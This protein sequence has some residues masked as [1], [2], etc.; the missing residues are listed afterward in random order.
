MSDYAA[1]RRRGRRLDGMRWN[2][3]SFLM[4]SGSSLALS[5]SEAAAARTR[6]SGKHAMRSNLEIILLK[7]THMQFSKQA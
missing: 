7:T 1:G 2:G 3:P 4:S 5:R 6:K